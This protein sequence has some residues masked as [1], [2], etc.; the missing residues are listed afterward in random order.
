MHLVHFFVQ[1]WSKNFV[2]LKFVFKRPSTVKS[3]KTIKS[4]AQ[5]GIRS[6]P[7]QISAY[8][9]DMGS[10]TFDIL[11]SPTSLPIGRVLVSLHF[12]SFEYFIKNFYLIG[13]W[14]FNFVVQFT[15]QR[16]FPYNFSIIPKTGR[17]TNINKF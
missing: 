14:C 13:S 10:A 5:F 4:R 11:S 16:L 3:Q 15:N 7:T 8:F 2:T 6:G 1:A 17:I 9:N 12:E